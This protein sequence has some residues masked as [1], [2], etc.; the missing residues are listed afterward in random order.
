MVHKPTLQV[1][2]D[3]P[4]VCRYF[5]HQLASQSYDVAAAPVDWS[6]AAIDKLRPDLM[7]HPE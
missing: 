6:F 2:D 4:A 7:E 1:I 5:R 3:H